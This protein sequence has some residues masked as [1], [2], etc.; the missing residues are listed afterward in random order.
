MTPDLE[1]LLS[2]AA[3]YKPNEKLRGKWAQFYPVFSTLRKNGSTVQQALDWLTAENC[4]PKDQQDQA[5]RAFM[6]ITVRRNR[7]K[8]S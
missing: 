8:G 7:K 1:A 4:I 3:T 5:Q 2:K 6:Q